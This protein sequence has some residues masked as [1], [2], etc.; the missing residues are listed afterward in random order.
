MAAV[1]GT[2]VA[3]GELALQRES[4]IRT[5][6]ELYRAAEA[7]LRRLHV[8]LIKMATKEPPLAAVSPT[9]QAGLSEERAKQPLR[10]PDP[11]EPSAWYRRGAQKPGDEFLFTEAPTAGLPGST[12]TSRGSG[13]PRGCGGCSRSCGRGRACRRWR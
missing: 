1:H 9:G 13:G 4:L 11:A 2:E 5:H 7:N 6:N 3:T 10:Q 8:D 12:P